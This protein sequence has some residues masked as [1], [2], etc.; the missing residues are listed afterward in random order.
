MLKLCFNNFIMELQIPVLFSTYINIIYLYDIPKSTKSIAKLI[1]VLKFVTF[2]LC[3][4][5]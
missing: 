5:F 1:Y 4:N 3:F 2:F